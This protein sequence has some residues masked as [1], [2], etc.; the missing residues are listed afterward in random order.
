MMMFSDMVGH[1]RRGKACQR[2]ERTLGVAAFTLTVV[3]L[4]TARALKRI[5]ADNRTML[6]SEASVT[7]TR[8][9]SQDGARGQS[10]GW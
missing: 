9:P 4:Q 7:S 8:E 6:M 5:F 3:V 10:W 2:A 1:W